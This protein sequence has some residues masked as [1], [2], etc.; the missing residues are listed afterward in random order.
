[1]LAAVIL[2]DVVKEELVKFVSALI[3]LFITWAGG[4]WL[5]GEWELRKKAREIDLSLA[6]QFQQ[7]FGEFKEI[8]RLW[9]VYEPKAAN[10]PPLTKWDLLTRASSAEGRV[11]AVLLKLAT[12]RQLTQ[13]KLITLGLFRQS[14]Q[15][16]RQGIRDAESLEYGFTS[17]RYRL[18]NRL[19]AEVAHIIVDRASGPPPT[20]KQAIDAFQTIIEVRT[21][22]LNAAEKAMLPYASLLPLPPDR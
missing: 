22:H 13:E 16:L 15:V 18:F 9:K 4:Y 11:E 14:F 10:A 17:A 6:M 1:M 20:A 19:G 3:I 8:W 5:L 21:E 2:E 7:L 12:D